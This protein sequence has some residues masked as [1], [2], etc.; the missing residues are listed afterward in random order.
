MGI[1]GA[2]EQAVRLA[3]RLRRSRPGPAMRWL[4]GD[5]ADA[6]RAR[7]ET[8][9]G[10]R[11]LCRA[12]CEEMSALRGGRPVH[13]RFECF[14]DEIEVTGLWLEFSDFDLVIVEERAEAVQQLVI[15]GH[16]LWHLHAGHRHPHLAG[17]AAARALADAPGWQGMPLTVAAR[18]GSREAEEAEA[19]DFGHR[20]AAQFRAHLVGSDTDTP[21]GPV[22]R[23]LGYRGRD[24]A[25]EAK[26]RAGA[27]RSRGPANRAPKKGG[28]A[29]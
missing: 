19:D 18:N 9:G 20:L 3:A 5:L 7:S 17:D 14:P 13:L 15:L 10:V 6:V 2:R 29:R 25:G 16:E 24:E 26:G 8:P 21:L 28:A 23:S 27:A 11:E 12:L 1:A 22:Q 4:A